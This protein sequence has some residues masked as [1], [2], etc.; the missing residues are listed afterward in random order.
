[1]D[2]GDLFFKKYSMPHPEN[3]TNGLSEKA[4][5]ILKSFNLM[6]YHAIGIGDD[7]LSLGKKFLIDL[8]KASRIPFLSSNVIDEDSGKPLF[9][10]YLIREVNGL[11]V[12]IFSLLSQDVFL[13]PSDP[14]RKGLIIRDPVETVQEM[15]RELGPQT[16]LIILLSH[17]SYP[18][19]VELAQ[20][21]SGIHIIVGGHTGNHLS[22]PPVIK[23]TVILQ[24][25]SQGKYAGRLDLTL[26]SKE[27]SF[28]N[29]NT[30]RS[31][32]NNLN[33]VQYQLTSRQTSEAQK[34]QW[35]KAKESYE[36]ALKQFEGKN[37][38]TNVI[39]PLSQQVK[40]H[41]DISKM[42]EAYKSKFPEKSEPPVHDSRG[43]YQPKP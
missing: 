4:R 42:V 15:V 41:P 29:E 36:S 32:K 17:L 3:E 27:A 1:L 33:R 8:S 23:N 11:K 18:K 26:L 25:S 6:G 20:K 35:Q 12:G 5:L 28:Y 19:D 40:D 7:D 10:R 30:K 24:T 16:D 9:Q 37:P 34:A 22:N 21:I 38:F 43:A 14:R 2:A 39:S 13:I 31:L